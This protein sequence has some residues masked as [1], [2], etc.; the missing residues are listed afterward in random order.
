MKNL[1]GLVLIGLMA[2]P[3]LYAQAPADPV[4]SSAREIFNRQSKFI[5]SAVQ[6]MPAAKYSFRPTPSQ[7]T[8]GKI[9][10]HVVEVNQR[11]CAMIGNSPATG[12]PAVTETD[13]KEALGHSLQLSFDY[14]AKTLDTLKDSRLGDTVTFF[15]NRK[16]PR[17][18]ALL[19]L[20]MDLTDHYS[21]MASYLRLNGLVP[22]SAQHG[23]K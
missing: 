18:R 4:V 16:V 14:C 9:I 10:A 19:E 5:T 20:D 1:M 2:A 21:Q 13:S 8:F 3:I 15:G 12:I 11:V 6:E 17:A 23:R 7:M 22:P